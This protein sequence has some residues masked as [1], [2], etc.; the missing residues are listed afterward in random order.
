MKTN[1]RFLIVFQIIIMLSA[2]SITVVY[3]QQ[4]ASDPPHRVRIDFNR[5]HDVPELYDD[6]ARLRAAYPEFLKLES[7]GKSYRGLDIMLMTINN[8]ET[9]PEMSKAAF[10]IEADIHGNE[11]Q[12]G[13]IALYTIWYLMENY[14]RIPKIKQIVDERVFYITP[15]VNPDGHQYF[16]EGDGG[17]ARTGHVPVDDDNDGLYDEDPSN[18][19][20]GNGVIEQIRKYVPGGGTHRISRDDER[21]LEQVPFGETGDWILLGSEGIDDDGDGRVNEDGPGGYDQNRNFGSDWQPRYVQ[22]GAMDY[23]FQLP[24]ARAVNDF[25]MSHP[26]IAGL[27]TY[28]NSAGQILRAPGSD[29]YGTYPP[30]D[31]RVY[32]EIGQNAERILPFY[33]YGVTWADLYT[34]HGGVTDWANDG[35]GIIAFLNELWNRR[36]YFNS[37]ELI[38]EQQDP[39]SPIGGGRASYF[40]DDYLEFGDQFADWTPFDHP[41]YGSVELGGRWKKTRGRVPPRFMLEELCHRNMAFTLYQAD[42]MPL[43]SMGEHSI[44]NLGG[45]YNVLVDITNSKL[46]PTI[47]TRTSQ[48]NVVR[49][50]LLTLEGNDIEVISASW[51]PDRRTQQFLNDVTQ[52]IGQHNLKRILIRNGHPGRTTR[53]I[54]YFVKGSGDFTVT[55]DSV[56]GGR[57]QKR[58]SLR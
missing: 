23:P 46:A 11:I 21:I 29:W 2:L 7:I 16:M 51:V 39:D 13:E 15:T 19:L 57:A 30:D 14:E 20:N 45:V 27:Q 17:G 55:Y 5:W 6:M 31:R 41:D 8:P 38:A 26:N 58:M 12:G 22:S 25:W 28:H 43:M 32:D 3:G 34:I 54:R 49:P 56:K 40:F 53:T 36:Q 33:E 1:K 24:E 50:D 10:Y 18:D 48:H 37:P 44:E 42:E 47:L 9:G 52:E 4:Y 35:L